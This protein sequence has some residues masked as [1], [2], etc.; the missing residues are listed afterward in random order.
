[1][2]GASASLFVTKQHG[3]ASCTTGPCWVERSIL[4]GDGTTGDPG[5]GGH[6]FAHVGYGWCENGT[7]SGLCSDL[8]VTITPNV[9]YYA[10][11]YD[12]NES[13]VQ[14]PS[15]DIDNYVSMQVSHYVSNGGGM[16]YIIHG[17]SGYTCDGT[18]SPVCKDAG[19]QQTYPHIQLKTEATGAFTGS[20]ANTALRLNNKWQ[21]VN[22]CTG[23][24]FYQTNDGTVTRGD[25]PPWTGWVAGNKPSQSSTGGELYDCVIVATNNPC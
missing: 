4:L 24:W 1:V 2:Y 12:F 18:L 19:A 16:M 22:G 10:Y 17:P 8:P 20:Y 6:H 14:V 15:G 5:G 7:Q 21:C 9:L 23:G 3:T 25:N 13:F 11:G